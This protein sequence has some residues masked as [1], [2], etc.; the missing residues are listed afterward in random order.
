MESGARAS[1]PAM[2]DKNSATSRT[3]RAMG[4]ATFIVFQADRVG[5]L[6]TRPGEG[7]NPTTEQ[8][9]AGLRREPPR[10][11]PSARGSIPQASATAA[12]PLE[13]PQVL[14]KSHGLRAAPKTGLN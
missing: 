14:D 10:S 5:T 6:G 9:L 4:P 13:P 2:A 3:V 1:G 7:R 12:P 11:V 8:K